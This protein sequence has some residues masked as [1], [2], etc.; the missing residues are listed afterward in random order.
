MTSNTVFLV[1]H[2]RLPV[3]EI[4]KAV[5]KWEFRID[6]K[7]HDFSHV[8]RVAIGAKWFAKQIGMNSHEQEL[9]YIAGLVHDL[10]RPKTEKVDHTQSSVELAKKML[11]KFSMTEK[12]SQF[13]LELVAMHRIGK[14]DLKKQVVFLA[15]KLW[16]Q[17]GV[18]VVFRR[19]VFV[20][21]VSDYLNWD[22]LKAFVH[23]SEVRLAKFPPEKFPKQFRR[24][25][26]AQQDWPLQALETARTKEPWIMELCEHCAKGLQAGESLDNI[27][28]S[29]SPKNPDAK[30]FQTE[31]I[32]Y[33]TNGK[34]G[35]FEELI[36][37]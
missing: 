33:I 26:K 34:L 18:Y 9:A 20:K 29:F 11:E 28:K 17:M 32:R 10:G 16:E 25:A 8:Q 37:L 36:D 1:R 15:D 3:E 4:D 27:I 7:S 13:V 14:T 5:R 31:A 21:E 30:R 35:D 23:Q 22:Q 6:F 12:D 24:L 2:N 19:A